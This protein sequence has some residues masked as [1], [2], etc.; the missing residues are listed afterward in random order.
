MLPWCAVG[1]EDPVCLIEL[2]DDR[3]LVVF[4]L[5]SHKP[6]IT[7]T[8]FQ[9]QPAMTCA[10]IHNVPTTK[11]AKQA[12]YCLWLTALRWVQVQG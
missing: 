7:N 9:E 3:Q 8:P 1:Y 2:L 6:T 10:M 5:L 12:G 4:D 11:P